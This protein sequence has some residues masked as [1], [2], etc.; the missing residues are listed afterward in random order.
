MHLEIRSQ[1]KSLLGGTRFL[2]AWIE[3]EAAVGEGRKE[4]EVHLIHL[5][6]SAAVWR[7]EMGETWNMWF[8]ILSVS[9]WGCIIADQD[10]PV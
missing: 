4:V 6:S 7:P 3:Q 8:R 10:R 1:R 2:S 5:R 9:W